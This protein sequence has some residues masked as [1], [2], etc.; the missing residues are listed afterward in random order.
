M[1]KDPSIFFEKIFGQNRGIFQVLHF[2]Y[3]SGSENA[4]RIKTTLLSA[5]RITDMVRFP[6]NCKKQKINNH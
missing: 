1:H 2:D 3:E 4:T 6:P 5:L